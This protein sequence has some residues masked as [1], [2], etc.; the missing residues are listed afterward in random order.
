MPQND[1]PHPTTPET[2]HFRVAIL[3]TG[4]GGLGTAIRLTQVGER[5][6]V[7]F[8]RADDLGGTWRDN[9]YPGCACDVQSH[10]YS[11][12]FALNPS[13]SRA[14]SPQPE[15]WNYLRACAVKFGI[16]PHLR[17]GHDV[18][19]LRWE[20]GLRRWRIETSRGTFTAD[21]VVSGVGGL[22]EP[23]LPT[24][25]GLESFAGEAFHSARWNHEH[26]L[27]GRR[28][29]VI[30]TGASAI[31]FVP[32]IQP[33]VS[34]LRLFQRTPP[35]ILPRRDRAIGK[36]W[37]RLYEA[38]PFAQRFVRNG[39]YASRELLVLG[40]MKPV[41]MQAAQR[42][43]RAHLAR[44]VRDPE[45]RKKLLPSYTIGC[46]RVLLSDDYYPSIAQPNVDVVTKRIHEV[47]PSGIVTD[48]GTLH[49]VDTIVFGTGFNA[50][51]PPIAKH[52]YGRGGTRLSDAWEGSPKAYLGTSVSG[53]PNLFFLLG[54]NSALGH[55]SVVYMIESQI[56]QVLAAL[57]FMRE[58]DAISV[59]ATASAQEAYVREVDADMRGTV[60]TSGGCASWYIDET[61]RNSTLWPGFTFSYRRRLEK[62][63]PEDHLVVLRPAA[64]TSVRARRRLEIAGDSMLADA[65][66]GAE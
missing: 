25:R 1:E 11:F 19:E 57:A 2:S 37:R 63:V 32:K 58:R 34:K 4:F 27:R 18:K 28:V 40:F 41:I 65:D 49:E 64:K 30:G 38:L 15:I 43:A 54:P 14:Y 35:W 56:E 42:L 13:W 47:R 3:G 7:L 59:E 33:L 53:F 51:D 21:V 22:S 55:S 50:T 6:F 24:V 5:D 60:W 62:F 48:D 10:L 36:S 20:D 17:F 61:G 44:Q 39:I 66:V 52:V 29:A 26:D 9:A 23:V 16:V 8:E 45:L 31:Q 46:K 12:S